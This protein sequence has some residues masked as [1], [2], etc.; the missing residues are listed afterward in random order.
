MEFPQDCIRRTTKTVAALGTCSY[1]V[2][3]ESVLVGPKIQYRN[4]IAS[5]PS[6]F[7]HQI[8]PGHLKLKLC[9]KRPQRAHV[10]QTMIMSNV[11][12]RASQVQVPL[13]NFRGL[14][15]LPTISLIGLDIDLRYSGTPKPVRDAADPWML[16]HSNAPA[17]I[18]PCSALI[19][20]LGELGP[21]FRAA[22]ATFHQRV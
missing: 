21:D 4:L 1:V 6:R 14:D 20:P 18:Q 15:L 9:L 17:Q 2:F 19:T 13:N 5:I 3:E 22:K 16:K 7:A 8:F 10:E 12:S 11:S